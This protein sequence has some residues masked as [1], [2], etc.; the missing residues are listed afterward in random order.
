[1]SPGSAIPD[2]THA[3]PIQ[4]EYHPSPWHKRYYTASIDTGTQRNI[5]GVPT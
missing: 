5:H 1:M 2:R 4:D 3:S